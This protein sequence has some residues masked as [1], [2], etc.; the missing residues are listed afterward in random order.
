MEIWWFRFEDLF[1]ITGTPGRR[2]WYAN[3]VAEPRVLI[4]T[5]FGNFPGTAVPVSDREFKR[6]FF[7]DGAS[8]WYSTQ[9]GLDLL[10]DTAPMIRV[11]LE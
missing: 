4:E 2:D 9:A 5:R 10:V 7:T 3:V 6:R 1:V 11:D 8:R